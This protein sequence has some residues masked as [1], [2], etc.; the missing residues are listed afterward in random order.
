MQGHSATLPELRQDLQLRE[1]PAT[2]KGEP[3]WLIYDPVRHRYFR[4]TERAFELLALWRTASVQ[5]MVKLAGE[6]L[7]RAV[8]EAEILEITEFLFANNLTTEPPSGDTAAYS[9]QIKA[10]N[11]SFWKSILHR[12]LFFR[13]PLCRPQSFL[14]KTLP[15]VQPLCSRGVIWAIVFISVAGLYLSTRQWEAF[16]TTFLDFLSLEGAFFYALSLVF[17]KVLHELGHAYTAVRHGVRVNT[18]GIAFMVLMPVLYTDVTDSWRMKSRRRKLSIDGAGMAVELSIAGIATFLWAFLPE[19]PFK[20]VAFFL[21]TTSW[22]MSL[23]INLNPFMRFDGYYILLDAWGIPNL[24]SRSFAMATWWIREKLFKLGHPAPEAFLPTK[25]KLVIGFAI[26]T[27][28]YRFLLFLGIALIVYHFFFKALGVILFAA[29][30][31]WFILRPVWRELGQWWELRGEIRRTSRSVATA[32]A[33][34]CALLLMFV[35]WRST[36]TFQAVAAAEQDL[37]LFAPRAAQ[38]IE[39]NLVDGRFVKSGDVLVRLHADDLN[40]ERTK[41]ELKIKR[42]H[43]RLNRIAGDP[44]DRLFLDVLKSELKTKQETLAGLNREQE[45]LTIKAPFDGVI[46]D[47][48]PDLGPRQWVNN[49]V[50]LGRLVKPGKLIARGYLEEDSAWRIA[51]AE[52]ASFVPA[53][54][55]LS[56]APGTLQSISKAGASELEIPYLATVFGGAVASDRDSDGRIVPRSGHYLVEVAL[57]A[58]AWRRAVRGTVQIEG[59]RESFG[60]AIWR[61]MLQ[62]LV[63]ESGV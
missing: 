5:E 63:R 62:V 41:V 24:Q 52:S 61:R 58:K 44:E 51:D 14:E 36:V 35:P 50:A 9:R 21:A 19:G 1:G 30:I 34:A 38:I 45:L 2:N 18:M 53:D 37:K 49:T 47:I 56:A 22:L 23:G 12:Y 60:A 31:I 20:S 11:P 7:N 59:A 3:S 6:K 42:L 10:A 57:D 33:M 32:F 25:Q 55:L 48:D 27:W 29:E 26:A 28:I 4:L 46:R 16:K 13:I 43:A 39:S 17:I 8:T 15:V 54:L 40:F